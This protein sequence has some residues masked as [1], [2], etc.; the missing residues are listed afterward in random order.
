MGLVLSKKR[1]PREN[2][3]LVNGGKSIQHEDT[4]LARRPRNF[5][6]LGHGFFLLLAKK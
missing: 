2:G 1:H 6:M 4:K 5:Y 3:D